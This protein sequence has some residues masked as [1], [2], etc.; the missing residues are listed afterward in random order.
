MIVKSLVIEPAEGHFGSHLQH[1][2]DR[3]LTPGEI[4]E[5]LLG[6]PECEDDE[7]KVEHSWR[8]YASLDNGESQPCAIWD[9]YGV[10]WSAFGPIEVFERLGMVA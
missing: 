10:R 1:R 4:G 3:A 2:L 7:G 6:L 9:Y 8:F 5:R